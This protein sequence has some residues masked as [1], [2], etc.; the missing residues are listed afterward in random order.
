[1]N[2]AVSGLGALSAFGE[3]L[4]AATSFY[5]DT[6]GLQAVHQDENSTV[7]DLGNTLVN[8][9]RVEAARDLVAPATV[10]P[11]EMGVRMQLTAWVEDVD[12]VCALLQSRGVVMLNGPVD[13]PW[14]KR[15]AA[16]VDPSGTVWEIAQDIPNDASG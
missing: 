14:G 8:L 9:L 4:D 11:P 5:R 16:F 2:A 6:L 15:T 13:R 10:A 3:D 12:A 7:F 1:M